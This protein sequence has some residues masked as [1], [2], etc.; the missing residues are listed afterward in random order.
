MVFSK[1]FWGSQNSI[2]SPQNIQKY[3][4]IIFLGFIIYSLLFCVKPLVIEGLMFRV[5]ANSNLDDC[6]C[7]I[8]QMVLQFLLVF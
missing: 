7:S 4:E 6:T 3:L 5:T 1:F 2:A 8:V